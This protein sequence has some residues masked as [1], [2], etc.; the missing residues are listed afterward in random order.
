MT[1]PTELTC[2]L[3]WLEAWGAVSAYCVVTEHGTWV[4]CWRSKCND[5]RLRALDAIDA[6]AAILAANR[7]RVRV[8]V[9]A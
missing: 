9:A 2:A 7:P 6:G 5:Y 1:D 8:Q 4:R 3:A